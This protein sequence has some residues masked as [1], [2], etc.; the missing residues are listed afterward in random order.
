[1][2]YSNERGTSGSIWLHNVLVRLEFP[3]G[4][5]H[6]DISVNPANSVVWLI[7]SVEARTDSHG[8]IM[9]CMGQQT[10]PYTLVN[11]SITLLFMG[12]A[13]SMCL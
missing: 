11:V 2:Y 7:M 1:M 6:G 3:P 4:L 10:L 9:Y 13:F 5:H 12:M 8:S